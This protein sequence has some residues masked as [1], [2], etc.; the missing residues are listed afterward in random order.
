M[1]ADIT[2]AFFPT[3]V[4]M[5][6]VVLPDSRETRS[7]C[8][9]CDGGCLGGENFS[10]WTAWSG[11]FPRLHFSSIRSAILDVVGVEW[12]VSIRKARCSE[13][14]SDSGCSDCLHCSDCSDCSYCSGWSVEN[15]T[16]PNLR[17]SPCHSLDASPDPPP[18]SPDPRLI[19]ARPRPVLARTHL[20]PFFS[21]ISGF[22]IS[23]RA[24]EKF[25]TFTHKRIT[26]SKIV[27]FCSVIIL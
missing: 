17:S 24:K 19:L 18:A 11:N 9:C 15:V 13:S 5:A 12:Q 16:L 10:T 6:L 3:L 14:G 22:S 23:Q 7:N 20:K 8:Q 4:V 21:N 27:M 25:T 26:N 2:L 1:Y